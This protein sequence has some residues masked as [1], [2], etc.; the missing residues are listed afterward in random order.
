MLT[1][2]TEYCEFDVLDKLVQYFEAQRHHFSEE[3]A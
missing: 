1:K 2:H 3:S